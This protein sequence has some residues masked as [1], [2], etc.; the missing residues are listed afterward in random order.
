MTAK[1]QTI[2]SEEDTA[3]MLC[4]P[5]CEKALLFAGAPAIGSVRCDGCGVWTPIGSLKKEKRPLKEACADC[6]W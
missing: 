5:H 1:D 3:E 4:C 2:T 6:G